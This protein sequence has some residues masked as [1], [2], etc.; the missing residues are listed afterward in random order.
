MD[1]STHCLSPMLNK[2]SGLLGLSELSNDVRVLEQAAKEGHG[3][4]CADYD[5]VGESGDGT[6]FM[7]GV[8]KWQDAVEL[9]LAG[10]SALQIGTAFFTDPY[11]PVKILDG[12]NQYLDNHKIESVTELTKKVEIW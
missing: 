10:A 4:L 1:V 12:L 6:G 3:D 7:G 9:L 2:Q 5:V 8:S 11:A